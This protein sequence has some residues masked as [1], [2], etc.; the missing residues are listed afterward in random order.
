MRGYSLVE[1]LTVLAIVGILSAIA[2]PAYEGY[3][4]NTYRSQAVADLKLCALALDRYYSNGF[5]YVNADG[6]NTCTLQSPTNGTAKYTISYESL[7]KTDYRI[8]A[9]PVGESCGSDNCIELTA[10]GTQ[11]TL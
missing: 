7:T 5:T 11:T 8:R 9:T 3:M 1:L 10:D 2:Y 4:S 6:A